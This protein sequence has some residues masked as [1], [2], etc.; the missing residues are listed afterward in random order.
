MLTYDIRIA[1]TYGNVK[2]IF[3]FFR[4][5]G[6]NGL[7]VQGSGFRV[8]GSGFR[9]QGSGFRVQV[10][11][12]KIRKRRE[13]IWTMPESKWVSGFPFGSSKHQP[14]SRK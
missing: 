3:D 5:N 4:K 2:D 9:V 13:Y 8:Q 11:R 6:M 1:F 10:R 7:R 14:L 12:I